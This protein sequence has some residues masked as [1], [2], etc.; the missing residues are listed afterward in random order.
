[1]QIGSNINAMQNYMSEMNQN[2]TSIAQT[3]TN[4][5][6]GQQEPQEA[7]EVSAS[8][9]ITR[10]LTDQISI[11]NGFDAQINSVQTQDDI[12]GT[13]IDMRG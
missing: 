7:Q 8:Q 11:E 13:L 3:T 2:A 5:I 10:D 9:D 6:E 1:M 4:A 12:M